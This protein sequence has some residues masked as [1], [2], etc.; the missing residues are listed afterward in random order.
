MGTAGRVGHSTGYGLGHLSE[1]SL[2]LLAIRDSLLG[3]LQPRG[4]GGGDREVQNQL[5]KCQQRGNG[6]EGAFSW[7]VVFP[8]SA[9][10]VQV[11]CAM[12]AAFL[13]AGLGLVE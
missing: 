8:F 10:L 9:H 4:G 7:E 1:S 3:Q 6:S 2:Q 13:A 5:N 12:G 11:L